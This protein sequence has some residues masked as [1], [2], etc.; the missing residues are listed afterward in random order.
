MFKKILFHPTSRIEI[1]MVRYG[2]VVAIAGPI[3]L[4]G[5]I[6][7]KSHFHLYVVLAATISFTVSM[8]VN[9]ILSILWVFNKD[10]GRQK[11]VDIVLFFIIGFV[12]LGIT[13]LVIWILAEVMSVNYIAAKLAAF[14][15]VF[16]W[17][18]GARRVLFHNKAVYKRFFGDKFMVDEPAG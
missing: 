16:F 3:D 5:Y 6:L 14:C 12:G 2:F 9:Y 17:S 10:T 11:H 8:A 7:L 1:Q 13:D 18:F 15:I 4:G